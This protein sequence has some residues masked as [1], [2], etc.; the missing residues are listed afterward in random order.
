MSP[1]TVAQIKVA[2]LVAGVFIL[3]VEAWRARRGRPPRRL[4][5]DVALGLLAVTAVAG[6][7]RFGDG[8]RGH[9]VNYHDVYHY[10]M[11]A[12]YSDELG[13]DKLYHCTLIATQDSGDKRYLAKIRKI[14]DLKTYRRRSK[15]WVLKRPTRCRK[16]FTPERWAEFT[17]DVRF[18]A[19]SESSYRWRRKLGDKG[20]NAT[21]WWN[22]VARPLANAVPITAWWGPILIGLIDPALLLAAWVLCARTFGLRC[23]L[24]TV[25]LF[26]ASYE[27]HPTHIR[28]GM[29]RLDWLAAGMAA[30]ALVARKRHGWAGALIG[31]AG[32]VRVFPGA[33]AAGLFMK[34]VVRPL[35]SKARPDGAALR[36]FAAMGLTAALLFG[37][38]V[39]ADGGTA[40]WKAWSAKIGM[41]VPSLSSNRYG[42]KYVATYRGERKAGDYQGFG[43]EG[44]PIRGFRA[45]SAHKNAFYRGLRVPWALLVLLTLWL[46]GRA[47]RDEEDYTA[48]GLSLPLHFILF[49]MTFYYYVAFALTA[50]VMAA[51]LDDRR[52]FAGLMGL[53]ALQIASH[54]IRFQIPFDY[55]FH[56]VGSCLYLAYSVFIIVL[57]Q[58]RADRSG[59]APALIE[60]PG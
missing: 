60:A 27:N 40:R 43:K 11:G 46:V 58:P 3:L 23:V 17:Q 25:L 13:Y 14:R 1:A 36:F 37:G 10:Y 8:V 29:L 31:Y 21:P 49:D 7:Y 19:R 5:F 2:L 30:I 42:F 28:G 59:G 44:R 47:C 45:M 26:G 6:Y 41:H 32:M 51:D 39:A 38:S 34:S 54:L 24:I 4:W 35:A 48:F 12:K 15:A 57:F 18:M 53:F 20:Y 50:L 56:F 22:A 33:Y 55:F 52:R 16:A 9:I